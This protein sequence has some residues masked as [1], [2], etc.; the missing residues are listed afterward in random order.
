MPWLLDAVY[1]SL[2]VALAPLWLYRRFVLHK[3]LGDWRQKILGSLPE[4]PSRCPCVWLHAVSVGEAVQLQ[5]IVTGLR[6]DYPDHDFVITTTTRTAQEVAQRLYPDDMVCYFPLDF[7][8]AVRR[9]L[10]RIRPSAIVLVELELWPNF[11]FAASQR[12]I[13]ITLIN[14]RLTERSLRGYRWIRWLTKM[15]FGRLHALAI[16]NESYAGR[17]RLLGAEP[18]KISLTGSIKFDRV[19]TDRGNPR[20]AELRR[21]FGIEPSEPVFIA[22]STQSPEEKIAIAAYLA[23]RPK[24]PRLRLLIVPRH[25][26]RFEEVAQLIESH[27][28]P[29]VRRSRLKEL[30]ERR[31]AAELRGREEPPPILLLDTLGELAACWGLADIAFVGGSLTNRGGQNMIEPA[32]YGAALLFGPNT[33]NFRDV[34]SLLLEADAARVVHDQDELTACV[35]RWLADPAGARQFGERAQRLVLAQQGAAARTVELI[36]T[37]L[38]AA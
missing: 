28:L 14:G 22:G 12:N 23:L 37:S 13:P 20:T 26:E 3:G 9:A 15:L 36:G 34:V 4:R 31:P 18:A 6:V 33:H 16:Q 11:I 27:C 19:E 2:A 25:K 29:L 5:P 32:G 1:L 17:F 21:S 30:G 35:E 24:Y 10:D 38:R 8:W 7:S